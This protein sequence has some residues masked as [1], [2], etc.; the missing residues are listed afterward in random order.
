MRLYIHV[1]PQRAIFQ[2]FTLKSVSMPRAL[3]TRIL[4]KKEL[5]QVACW[6]QTVARD[7]D[8]TTKR[9]QRYKRVHQTCLLGL[10]LDDLVLEQT[11]IV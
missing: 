6:R 11:L 7:A 5:I 8:Y 1:E 9:A 10:A 3:M 2:S 4:R